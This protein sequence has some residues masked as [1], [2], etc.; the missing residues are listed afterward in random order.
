[1]RRI[2]ALVSVVVFSMYTAIG[3]NINNG[4]K[5]V[6]SHPNP[7]IPVEAFTS[8]KGLNFQVVINKNFNSSKRFTFFNLTQ[9][10]GNYENELRNNQFVNQS[11]IGYRIWKGF[12]I[13][14]GASI[15]PV[16][17]FRPTA[18]L[19]FVNKG[20]KHLF[21]LLPRFDLTETH[22][23]EVFG[24][25]EY[26][27]KL[28][29]KISLYTRLQGLYNYNTD[30]DFHGRSYVYSRLGISYQQ[31]QFGLGF[32]MDFYGPQKHQENNFGL[33]VRTVFF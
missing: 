32:N 17:G 23:F 22:N 15:V 20:R 14:V 12:S 3:Q 19:Q 1:M 5:K 7:P 2:S 24:L 4:E 27:P 13:N 6:T 10:Y 26:Q 30:M 18:G 33:F 9:Y 8:D 31:F 29:E 25:A 28:T 11:L 21:I 16:T